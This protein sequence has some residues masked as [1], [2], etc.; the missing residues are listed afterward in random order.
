M[1]KD[2]VY[3]GCYADS[4]AGAAV[5]MNQQLWEAAHN[6]P[7]VYEIARQ[8]MQGREDMKRGLPVW[9][10][11]C[12]AFKDDKRSNA[13]ALI[14]LQRL[15]LDFDVKGNTD[16]ILVKCMELQKSGKW[17]ILL[18]EDSIRKGTHVLIELP[19]WMTVEEAQTQFSEDVGFQADPAVKDVARCIYMVPKEYVRY[20]H[21]DF[22][23]PNPAV[24]AEQPVAEEV[25]VSVV[26]E[27]P[28]TVFPETYKGIPYVQIVQELEAVLGGKPDVGGRNN[29]IFA[30]ACH[31]RYV[32]ND[33]PDWIAAVLPTYGEERPKWMNTIKSA[34]KRVQSVLMSESIKKALRICE[35]NNFVEM[36][37][38]EGGDDAPPPMP[39]DLPELMTV[40]LSCMPDVYKPATANAVF[41]PLGAHLCKTY[42]RYNDNSLHEATLMCCLLAETGS[43]KSSINKPINFIMEDIDGRDE[44]NRQ[45]D[46]EWK[47]EMSLK[48]ANKTGRKRPEGLVIQHVE[49]DMTPAALV[50]R[51]ADAGDYF[52]YA[53]TNELDR[54]DNLKNSVRAKNHFQLM[55]LAFDPDNVFGQER[56]GPN[57]VCERV[58]VRFNWN[59]SAT[60]KKGKEYFREV[61]TDGPISRINFCTIPTPQI[62]SKM[63]VFGDYD[64]GFKEKL[65]PYIDRLNNARGLV[66]CEE[67]NKFI[68]VLV[69]ECAAFAGLSESRVYWNLSFRACVIAFLKAMVLYVAHGEKWDKK[70]ED[71]IR[72]S[73]KYDMWCKM[74]FFGKEIENE[75]YSTADYSN[76]RGPK[77]LLDMLPD[78]FT[79]EEAQQLRQRQNIR[80]GS[81][82]MML[83]NWKRRGYIEVHGAVMDSENLHRQQY[84][85]TDYYLNNHP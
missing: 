52:L 41:P 37:D 75:E 50:Q 65:K 56:V 32:C 6:D 85:K 45:R 46:K 19:Q 5:P 1:E 79:R 83:A 59:A 77:N 7:K 67:I 61:L 66:V 43:G 27:T 78:V 39:A 72:W 82:K 21:P 33:D 3:F 2:A 42:F 80:T 54:F 10:P 17:K 58:K 47:Q 16:K 28:R 57:A 44:V 73:L 76:R 14:P 84:A 25:P 38:E 29:H 51:L 24:P 55:C 74:R 23:T 20:V 11:R 36:S 18:V 62:G 48:G 4:V 40:L 71:F 13:N 22:F 8:V 53:N 81:L 15:M 12:A 26:S 30:M 69:G 70:C 68:E 64:N 49:L 34:C 9:I 35:K 31:L 60:I 63:P